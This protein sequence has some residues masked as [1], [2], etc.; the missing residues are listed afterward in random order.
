M[1]PPPTPDLDMADADSQDR[2]VDRTG[3]IYEMPWA[4]Q[5]LRVLRYSDGT[6]V[7]LDSTTR[8]L[9]AVAI[10]WINH[11]IRQGRSFSAVRDQISG[12]NDVFHACTRA[13][14]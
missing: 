8:R 13:V 1:P 10:G 11:Q 9:A 2:V 12:R 3:T 6:L 7:P 14:S 5:T 4:G